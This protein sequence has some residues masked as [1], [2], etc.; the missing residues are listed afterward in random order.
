MATKWSSWYWQLGLANLLVI[1]GAIASGDC[2][3]AQI[4]PDGTLG[5]ES[6]VITPSG[7]VDLLAGGATRG[8][9]LFQSFEQFSVPTGDAVYFNNASD[10][11]NIISRVT[12]ASVTYID[13]LIRANANANLFLIN[14]N[15]FIF[16]PNAALDLGGSFLGTT[17]SSLNFADS[18][19]FSATAPQTLPLLSVGV[20]TGLQFEGTGGS[21][22]N[23]SIAVDSSGIPVGLQVQP[24]KTLALVGGDV[25]LAGGNLTA[26][27]GRI[28]L[29]SVASPSLVSLS[30]TGQG[31]VLGYE[32]VQNFGDIQLSQGAFVDASGEGSGDIQVQGGRVTLTDGSQISAVTT[33]SGS[34]G[35]VTVNAPD[36]V[37]LIGTSADGRFPSGLLTQTQNTGNAGNLTIQTGQLIVV[38]GA[39]LSVS[40]QGS[41]E[42]GDL[43]VVASSIRLA[44]GSVVTASSEKV[45]EP[46]T[47]GALLLAGLTA[48]GYGKRQKQA[49]RD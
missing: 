32:G 4:V 15:G 46:G 49:F 26:E 1:G 7:F 12:G 13:G 41:G 44:T 37:E 47:V 2:S 23:Q 14:P 11:Q 3:L 45:P 36:S 34:G 8:A 48:L 25:A 40:S 35:T 38:D 39:E 29:G 27:A 10:I 19:Q 31:W 42:A 33:G 30:P 21:I 20:P 9:N 5:A 16:G 6:S 28:E 22:L 17:A 24:G 18:T 43:Q